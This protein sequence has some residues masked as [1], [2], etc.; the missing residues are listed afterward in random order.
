MADIEM[1]IES[2]GNSLDGLKA[3]VPFKSTSSK[4]GEAQNE[5]VS[6]V[7][8]ACT[9]ILCRQADVTDFLNEMG[10]NSAKADLRLIP[11][12]PSSMTQS[13]ATELVEQ[14]LSVSVFETSYESMLR[15]NLPGTACSG[16]IAIVGMSGRFPGA[17]STAEY[18]ECNEIH[19]LYKALKKYWKS[20]RA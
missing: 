12:G 9:D 2:I 4:T 8:Q 19:I 7:R 5:D 3:S 16:Q 10:K 6:L 17:Q 1:C 18:C 15:A 20:L 13:L 14:G 11:V